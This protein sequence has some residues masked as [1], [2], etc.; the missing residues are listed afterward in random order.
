MSGVNSTHARNLYYD[1]QKIHKWVAE[2]DRPHKGVTVQ[3]F[4]GQWGWVCLHQNN[5]HITGYQRRYKEGKYDEVQ[6]FMI[7][8]RMAE[9]T[10][11]WVNCS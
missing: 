1:Y 5:Q 3:C 2:N 6:Y 9:D 7:P 11:Y 10:E 8:Y 4:K